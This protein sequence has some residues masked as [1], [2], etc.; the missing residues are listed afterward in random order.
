MGYKATAAAAAAAAASATAARSGFLVRR[1]RRVVSSC[2]TVVLCPLLPSV[3]HAC[4]AAKPGLAPSSVQLAH[5][6]VLD[7]ARESL[8]DTRP[9]NTC[10]RHQAP[11]RYSPAKLPCQEEQ[12]KQRSKFAPK[13]L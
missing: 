13:L 1:Q 6:F 7:S 4:S 8:G 12:Q 5:S 9:M 11:H 2:A 10:A 3:V